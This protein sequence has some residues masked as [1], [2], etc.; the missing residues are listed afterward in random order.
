LFPILVVILPSLVPLSEPQ[1]RPIPPGVRQ[2]DKAEAQTEKNIPP[3]QTA[4]IKIDLAQLSAEADELS[5]MS[6]TVPAD[7]ASIRN[8]L[9]PKDFAQKLKRIEKLA[10]HM[11]S[12]IER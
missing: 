7:A 4:P 9:L 10:K 1:S 8:G 2:A 6:Q 5:K 3:P 12:Q 11:R